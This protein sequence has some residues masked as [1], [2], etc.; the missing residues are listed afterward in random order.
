MDATMK[1]ILQ[2]IIPYLLDPFYKVYVFI[3]N[4]PL[5]FQHPLLR[6]IDARLF[7]YYFFRYPFY[8]FE[9]DCYQ[10][11]RP[12]EELTIGHTPYFSIQQIMSRVPVTKKSRFIDLG[13]GQGEL[14]F[15]MA[16]RYGVPSTGIDIIQTYIQVAKRIRQQLKI[17]NAQFLEGD[18]LNRDLSKYDIV[19]VSPTCFNE[20]SRTKISRQCEKLGS[21]AYV[22]SI[23][24][25]IESDSFEAIDYFSALFSWGQAT[26]YIQKK[27]WFDP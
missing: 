18:V 19:W 25:P 7:L 6:K 27:Q 23:S 2:S 26:V 21:G 9:R 13:S 5:Y 8:K 14:V 16:I 22:I 11:G 1:N 17:A 12:R 3:R 4:L 24:Y 20:Q 15:Y 10:S